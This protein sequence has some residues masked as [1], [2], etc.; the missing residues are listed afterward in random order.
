M[1][2]SPPGSSIH[3][4]LQAR[5][6]EWGPIAFSNLAAAAAGKSRSSQVTPVVKN[7]PANAGDIRD[8]GL[9]L[10]SG[11]SPGIG[12]GNT[13]QYSCWKIP[14]TEEPGGLQSTRLQRRD[15][16]EPPSTELPSKLG[17][18]FL[19][20]THCTS[21]QYFALHRLVGGVRSC[22]LNKQLCTSHH[23]FGEL[24]GSLSVPL[25]RATSARALCIEI[26]ELQM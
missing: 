20:K 6:L 25:H 14:C 18:F 5:V 26:C 24:P 12:N 15:T 4:I 23:C 19:T 11:R 16:I 3:G 8:A 9:I 17:S 1:D 7:P 22:E 21:I 2:C 10:R 13:L